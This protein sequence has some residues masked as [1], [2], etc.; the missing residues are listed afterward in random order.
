MILVGCAPRIDKR[1]AV[2]DIEKRM[3]RLP[4]Y[5]AVDFLAE[6]VF[7]PLGIRGKFVYGPNIVR[8]SNSEP[9]Q[10]FDAHLGKRSQIQLEVIASN[11]QD[12][13]F[14][15]TERLEHVITL[16]IAGVDDDIGIFH[17]LEHA[18]RNGIRALPVSVGKDCN[19]HNSISSFATEVPVWCQDYSTV[20]Y[21]RW[22]YVTMA[23]MNVT[24]APRT[25]LT[26][27][28]PV[29]AASGTFGYGVEFA[30]RMDVSGL[31]AIVCK[32]TTRKPRTGN[33]P[34]RLTETPAGMLNAIGLQNVGVDAVVGEKA[35]VWADWDVPVLVNVSGSTLEE[36]VDVISRLQGVP[37]IAGVELN[38]SCPNVKEGGVAFGVDPRLAFEVT[39]AARAATDLP[40]VVKLSPNVTDIGAI[41]AQ[42]ETAGADAVSLI[43]T[44]YGVAVD[45][46]RKSVV[47]STLSG[48]LSGPAV[49]PYALYLVY[50]VAQTVTV[51]VIGIGGILSA[52]DA[53]EYM[54]IGAS[55]VQVGTALMLDPTSW[56]GIV[57][58]IESWCAREG[59]NDLSEIIGVAN[60]GFNKNA[61]KIP[62]AGT[63]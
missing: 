51:P 18:L 31:G 24:I 42:V 41:A 38:I 10:I 50:Q 9:I 7:G 4:K 30:A 54:L 59:V 48:G 11:C 2:E 36:Y 32:G 13:S 40:L 35:P 46:D 21:A 20:L 47:L 63:G 15:L 58:G 37:G 39:A 62:L 19:S 14:S 17:Q 56:Q 55:A 1:N 61:G 16:Q 60:P 23:E 29:I 45:A 25:G 53:I 28:N 43:N 3:V 52:E 49:K 8:Y 26:L 5:H 22:P 27:K 57:R 6:E 34:I 33:P 12:R 44:V